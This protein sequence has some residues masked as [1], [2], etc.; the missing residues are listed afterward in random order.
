[1]HTHKHTRWLRSL[2]EA[3]ASII[4]A[5]VHATLAGWRG[6]RQTEAQVAAMLGI[7]I[8]PAQKAEFWF[9]TISSNWLCMR[10]LDD[11]IKGEI[12]LA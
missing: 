1:M 8:L 10:L 12:A 4:S 7:L 9:C 5:S 11:K 2:L 6:G 3:C